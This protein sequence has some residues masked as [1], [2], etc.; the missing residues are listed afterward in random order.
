MTPAALRLTSGK[1]IGHGLP[2]FL[3]AEIGNNHQ[4]RLEL[5]E[6]LVRAAA[7]AGAD[8]VKFQKRDVAALLT[9]AGRTAS[10]RGPNSFGPTYGAHRQA[11]ELDFE[12][13][14]ALKALSESLGL[15]FFASAWDEPSLD[16]LL[17]LKVELLKVASA[18]L[19]SLPLIRRMV[20]SGLPIIASTGMSRWPEIDAAV[21]ELTAS[22]R[23]VVLLHCNSSYPTADREICL[24]V[25]L[26]LARRY[27]LPVGYSGHELGYAPSL[28]A[29][30]LGAC[31]VE[32][33]FTLDKTLPGTDH[34]ASLTP[35]E[36]A[37]MAAMTR[38][39]ER[40]CTGSAKRIFSGEAASA[41]KLKKAIVA[42]RDLA[43][44]T[45]LAPGDLA[46]KC[47]ADGLP[48][49]FWDDVKGLTLLA[50][51][52]RDEPLRWELLDAAGRRA[53]SDA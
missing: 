44:G 7:K 49:L 13:L 36:F 48:T 14:A 19:T 33:H 28:A 45:V 40:A 23:Q 20:R 17:K 30:A 53:S 8:A 6:E 26:E 4:G 52:A 47:P 34:G 41:R 46:I 35:A 10:Y 37:E 21:A 3:V 2:C 11:L 38:Q 29:A 43:A 39:I 25:M 27:E 18:D 16:G 32:R 24:P 50:D 12:E 1:T 51:L 5:A 31:L 22:H 15:T 9:R 42:A